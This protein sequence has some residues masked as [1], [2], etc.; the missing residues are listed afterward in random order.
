MEAC[1]QCASI[2][3]CLTQFSAFGTAERKKKNQT[4]ISVFYLFCWIVAP[5]VKV[6]TAPEY[7]EPLYLPSR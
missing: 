5:E 4:R 2:N 7:K 1:W 6:Y 3:V